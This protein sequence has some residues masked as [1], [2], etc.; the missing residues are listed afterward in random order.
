MSA[1][2]HFRRLALAAAALLLASCATRSPQSRIQSRPEAFQSLSAKHK[3]M[4]QRG[5]I[6]EGMSKDGV[7]LAWGPPNRIY[8]GSESGVALDIWKYT[9]LRPVYHHSIGIGMGYG[10]GRNRGRNCGG[11]YPGWMDYDVGPTYV[12]YTAAEVR[13]ANNRVKSWQ[14]LR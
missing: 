8:T 3:E 4:V 14:E 6:E 2:N 12:P 1:R 10:W 7:W 5:Q 13:F 11:Y 9:A